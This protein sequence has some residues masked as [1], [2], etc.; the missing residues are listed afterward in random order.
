M[1]SF[2]IFSIDLFKS[3]QTMSAQNFFENVKMMIL[4][5]FGLE[6]YPFNLIFIRETRH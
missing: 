3:N 2:F 1:T 4:E 6:N 5:F